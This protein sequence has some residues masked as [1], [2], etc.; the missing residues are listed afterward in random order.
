MITEPCTISRMGQICTWLQQLF[1][2]VVS[3]FVSGKFVAI[4]K[5]FNIFQSSLVEDICSVVAHIT[6]RE[7]CGPWTKAPLSERLTLNYVLE[8]LSS[9]GDPTWLT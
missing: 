6:K 3:D 1:P 4:R 8:I 9:D 2:L 5:M 7:F